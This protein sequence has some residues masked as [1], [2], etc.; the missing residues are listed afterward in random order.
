MNTITFPI[1]NLKDLNKYLKERKKTLLNPVLKY[2][3]NLKVMT[4][5]A[6]TGSGKSHAVWNTW[7]S[8]VAKYT[9]RQGRASFD[10]YW[11]HKVLLIDDMAPGVIK[12][13]SKFKQLLEP[14]PLALPVIGGSVAAEYE[15]VVICSTI[16]P[17]EWF[18]RAN[19]IEV[20]KL[21]L[22]LGTGGSPL[23]IRAHSREELLSKF[24]L[25]VHEP[26][27]PEVQLPTEVK[28]SEP[29]DEDLTQPPEKKMKKEEN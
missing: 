16:E 24:A 27:M 7:T 19:A 13:I 18:P 29:V 26:G 8:E 22:L 20:A 23:Y 15:L 17:F 28:K 4:L 11:G 5:I 1:T 9:T 25:A 6:P 3:P 12:S 10:G 14:Y 2:R 21:L